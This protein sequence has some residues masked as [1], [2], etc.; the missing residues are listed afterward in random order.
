MLINVPLEGCRC[1]QRVVICYTPEPSR[2]NGPSLA[3]ER[4]ASV[5]EEVACCCTVKGSWS[6]ASHRVAS[7]QATH[8]AASHSPASHSPSPRPPRLQHVRQARRHHHDSSLQGCHQTDDQSS[9]HPSPF[10]RIDPMRRPG[11]GLKEATSPARPVL[12][13]IGVATA[14]GEEKRHLWTPT[15]CSVG[16]SRESQCSVF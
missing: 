1:H 10:P 3:T 16:R 2:E 14:D 13:N 11:P 7:P 8:V 9:P 4:R 5:S 12:L 6:L 15:V